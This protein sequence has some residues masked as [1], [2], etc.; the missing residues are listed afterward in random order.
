MKPHERIAD[1]A[2]AL[3]FHQVGFHPVTVFEELREIFDNRRFLEFEV[4][5][6]QKRI[7][8]M[9]HYPGGKTF[10]AL[11]MGYPLYR[12]PRLAGEEVRVAAS[13]VPDYHRV[14]R[15]GLEKL[16]DF[17]REEFGGDG[18]SFVD[19]EGL[20]DRRVAYLCGLGF[21]GRHTQI[22]SPYLGST[23]NI[24]YLMLDLDLGYLT[25]KIEGDCG[26]CTR[27][28][29]ACPTGA[30]R[31]DYTLDGQ[32]C[33]SY[34]TQKK[35]LAGSE[36]AWL[37][38]CI[39]GCDLCLRACPHNVVSATSPDHVFNKGDFE[40]LSQRQ[41]R[42]IYGHRDFSFR[43]VKILRRNIAFALENSRKET[44]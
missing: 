26:G 21:Y 8:P 17:I 43:G 42:K 15:E 34:L 32:A 31:G 44:E 14:V 36:A 39:Y 24:G 29:E 30:I 2:L 19:V 33:L 22:I 13:R 6:P 40:S 41:Y 10:V 4:K 23:F 27:C 16:L 3:G 1:K 9:S 25:P 38:R 37:N 12:L 18:R 20:D 11:G 35:D 7:D 5:D 28:V